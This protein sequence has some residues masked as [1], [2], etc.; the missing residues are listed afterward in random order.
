MH[1]LTRQRRRCLIAGTQ[2]TLSG[3]CP[4]YA[5]DHDQHATRTL[6][7][8]RLA[9]TVETTNSTRALS[10]NGP[11]EHCT[12]V[13]A[14]PHPPRRH[15]RIH[16]GTTNPRPLLFQDTSTRKGCRQRPADTPSLR[17]V[18]RATPCTDHHQQTPT[19]APRNLQ[20]VH[21][22]CTQEPTS[23]QTNPQTLQGHQTQPHPHN[24]PKRGHLTGHVTPARS[25][26][27]RPRHSPPCRTH[28][29][30]RLPFSVMGQ[31]HNNP[32]LSHR[33]QPRH[34]PTHPHRSHQ[35]TAPRTFLGNLL[36]RTA[37][38]RR[39]G[40]SRRAMKGQGVEGDESTRPPSTPC[41][42]PP[43]TTTTQGQLSQPGPTVPHRHPTHDTGNR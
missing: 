39:T 9:K 10:R 35:H 5:R 4:R 41:P 1:T 18:D 24:P 11:G 38:H 30:T 36:R 13:H 31:S 8:H 37:R 14:R 17:G 22:I 2:P 40:R 12:D 42:T 19:H 29:T 15:G 32:A 20:T 21:T 7:T 43:P 34:S 16:I 28:P 26:R 3:P 25:R 33:H 23:K 27:R 6:R